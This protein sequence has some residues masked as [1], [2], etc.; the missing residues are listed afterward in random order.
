MP[1][2]S[3]MSL[4]EASISLQLRPW[5]TTTPRLLRYY[6]I[7]LQ[8]LRKN[9]GPAPTAAS[10]LANPRNISIRSSIRNHRLHRSRATFRSNPTFR[11]VV[12]RRC[13]S[14]PELFRSIIPA[15]PPALVRPTCF[16]PSPLRWPILLVQTRLSRRSQCPV[17]LL[18]PH[19]PL[20]LGLGSLSGLRKPPPSQE[21]FI[22]PPRPS[23][24]PPPIP[25]E[26]GPPCFRLA[27]RHPIKFLLPILPP[28]N[29]SPDS[30]PSQRRPPKPLPRRSSPRILSPPR[31][32]ARRC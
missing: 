2:C 13:S 30:K 5:R 9:S 18:L 8:S 22:Y 7:C 20:F 31:M 24:T 3:G 16:L 14:V 19:H 29:T 15:A 27:S 28:G 23:P 1:P 11:A 12:S 32:G 17:L 26:S 6:R 10:C 25:M 4:T 21:L